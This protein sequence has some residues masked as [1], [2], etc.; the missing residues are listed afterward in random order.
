MNDRKKTISRYIKHEWT[1]LTLLVLLGVAVRLYGINLPLVDSHQIR[2]TQ[3]AMMTRNIYYDNMDIF[4]TRLDFFGNMPGYVIMEFPLMHGITALLYY[5][6]GPCD[7]VGRMVSVAF[8][9]G[10]MFLMYF[11]ARQ[12]LPRRASFAALTLYAFSPMNIFFSR[13]FMPESSMMFFMIGALYFILRWLKEETRGLY[14]TAV[15]F[16]AIVGLIK[17]TAGVIFV[18]IFAAWFIKYKW[19]VLRRFNF[20]AYVALTL[21]PVVLWGAYAHHFNAM[22]PCPFGYDIS[23][24]GHL[25]TR[26]ITEHWFNLK[27]YKFVGGSIVLLLLTPLGFLG[28]V[29]GVLCVVQDN[30]RKILYSWL[31][32]IIAY[33]YVLAG[34]NSGHIYY[35]L[36]LLPLGAIFFGFSVEWLFNKL[37]F[38]KQIFKNNAVKLLGLGLVLFI[39]AGYGIG[40]FKYF[41][42]MYD[43]TLRMPYVLEVSEI[44]KKCTPKDRFI[45]LNQGGVPP[46]VLAYYSKG[47]TWLFIAGKKAIKEFE[48]MRTWGATTY[49]AINSKYTAGVQ[50]TKS[51]KDFW[52]YLNEKYT[53]IAVTDNYLIFD[54]RERKKE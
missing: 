5:V 50:Q 32:A 19:Q 30:Q 36:P 15:I 3:T 41:R 16:A 21:T 11:L 7:I 22:N 39:L 35:H 29:T 23:W 2:Q 34:P 43:T 40:Y 1:V 46:A 13:A 25:K 6:F 53:P 18:P 52:R 54:V 14:V 20:W 4:N 42:Y 48:E 28:T 10:A 9:V 8:S 27:F 38:F 17:P 24:I 31:G 47:K 49:V 37:N 44:I 45:I 12:F 33:F 26:G 51:N